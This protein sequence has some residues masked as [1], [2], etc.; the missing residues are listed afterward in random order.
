MLYGP[1]AYANGM[2]IAQ[3]P[4]SAINTWSYVWNPGNKVISGTYT[5]IA[6]DKQNIAF[7]K[8][9]FSVVGG[10][11][12]SIISSSTIV[13]QGGA[14]TFSGLCTTGANSVILTLYGPG[15]FSGGMQ[16]ATLSLNADNTYSYKYTF[17]LSK[18]IGTYTMVVNDQQN[19]ASASVSITL[20][21]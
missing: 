1:G 6:S 16:I 2:Q 13:P 21:S 15:Q 3:V 5:M 11:S 20:S 4:V 9:T 12:V 17:D 10:G 19:T 14:V 8:A 7:D 18:P